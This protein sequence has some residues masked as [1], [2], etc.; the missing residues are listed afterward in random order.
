VLPSEDLEAEADD[1]GSDYSTD[2]DS[3]SGAQHPDEIKIALEGVRDSLNQLNELAV[4]IRQSSISTSAARIMAFQ[5]KEKNKDHFRKFGKLSLL[6]VEI[7]YPNAAESLRNQ[8][9]K[10]ILDRYARLCYWSAHDRKLQVDSRT[11]RPAEQQEPELRIATR[12]TE[13]QQL[14]LIRRREKTQP[15]NTFN[16][17][18]TVYSDTVATTMKPKPQEVKN[19]K[20]T[21]PE[22]PAT[23]ARFSQAEFPRPPKLTDDE[24]DARCPFCRKLHHRMKYADNRWWKYVK[25]NSERFR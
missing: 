11:P 8:L 16:H 9:S 21:T 22:P 23:S 6:I 12:A 20:D 14:P 24:L 2:S 4:T 5:D 18:F 10:S 19:D 15:E 1:V 17:A 3:G 7:L 13:H 25:S